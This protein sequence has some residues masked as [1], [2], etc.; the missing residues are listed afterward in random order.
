MTN[1]SQPK[2]I[3]RPAPNKDNAELKYKLL[4]KT[5]PDEF[6]SVLNQNDLDYLNLV[7]AIEASI[8]I[9]DRRKLIP[10]LFKYIYHAVPSVKEAAIYVLS[11]KMTKKIK[12]EFIK[13]EE[14]EQSE[15]IRVLLNSL[16]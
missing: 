7:L 2:R 11:S 8:L 16:I 6:L 14:I 12:K 1:P 9:E 3:P 13:A 15:T 5:D 10:I 4:A